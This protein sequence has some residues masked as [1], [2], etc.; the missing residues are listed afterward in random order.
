MSNGGHLLYDPDCGFCTRSATWLEARGVRAH[1]AP[2]SPAA[3]ELG[4]DLERAQREVPFV[5]PDG[6]VTYGARAIA[7]VMSTGRGLLRLGGG[8]LSLAPVQALARPVYRWVAANRHDLPG[9]T[10]ECKLPPR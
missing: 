4:V 6:R 1:V 10:A 8:I 9:G 5:R 3:A 2:L 7:D